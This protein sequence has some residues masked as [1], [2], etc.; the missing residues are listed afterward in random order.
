MTLPQAEERLKSTL[1]VDYVDQDWCPA[2]NAVLEAENDELKAL[3]AIEK[4]T[5]ANNPIS[6][7]NSTK[8]A[9]LSPLPAPPQL[10]DVKK[11]LIAVVD[12]LKV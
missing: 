9:T 11:G 8:L 7:T 2:L 4:L 5:L 1:G 3:Q 12:E 6:T 10:Q